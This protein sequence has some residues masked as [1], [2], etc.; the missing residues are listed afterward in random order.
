[1]RD[2]MVA[3]I[4]TAAC[5]LVLISACAVPVM[6][7]ETME[8]VDKS[9][10]FST[11]QQNPDAVRGSVV[12]VGGQILETTPKEGETW[13]E[14]LEK[15]LD[16]SGKPVSA[17]LSSGRFL[18]RFQGFLE[19]T[20]YEKGR[21][22]TVAGRVDGKVIRPIGEIDYTYPLLTATEHYLWNTDDTVSSPRIGIGIGIGV[23]GGTRGGGAVGV[24]F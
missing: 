4:V 23:G 14:V 10:S 1:M 8:T 11:I 18:V 17:D 3:R 20:I 19:P 16:R 7:P 15:P 24:E 13:I 2:K 9:I 6:T 5:V 12:L 22:L 21:R